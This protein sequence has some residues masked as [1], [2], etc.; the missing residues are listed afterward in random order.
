MILDIGKKK[1]EALNEKLKEAEK[2]DLL[3]F[4]LGAGESLQTFEGID[5]SQAQAQAQSRAEMLGILD[6]GKR[7]RNVVKTY[8]ESIL[9]QQAA[10][11][12]MPKVEKKKKIRL[13]KAY[14]LPRMDEWQMYD[15]ERLNAIQEE[16]EAL[17]KKLLEEE[18]IS[19]GVDGIS[20]D[21]KLL[22][23]EVLEE[24][25]NLLKEG[26]AD[27]S[28]QDFVAFV[29]ASATF[30]REEFDSIA[31]I[32]GKPLKVIEGYASKF[33]GDIGKSRISEKEYE[34]AIIAIERGEKKLN[35]VRSME[36]G[37]SRFVSLF[38]D[39]WSDLEFTPRFIYKDKSFTE[40]E[41]RFLLCWSHKFGHG[42]W[43]AIRFAIRRCRAFRFN[44]H[45][46]SLTE[47][48]IGRRCEQ[49]MRTAVKEID[50]LEQLYREEAGLPPGD[51]EDD[52]NSETETIQLPKYST[53][54]A[55]RKAKEEKET[56]AE[57]SRLEAKVDE[58][59]AE[60]KRIQA[61]LR[62]LERM[63]ENQ[64]KND[65]TSIVGD[66]L[67]EL[68]NL[69]ASSGNKGIN[70]VAKEF[71]LQK[72]FS[73]PQI[74]SKIDE[75]AIKEKRES[76]GD[77]KPMWYIKS[78]FAHLVDLISLRKKRKL[79]S[80]KKAITQKKKKRANENNE[81]FPQYDG[82]EPP[83][84]AKKDF[85]LFCITSRRE[86]KASLKADQRKDKV[87]IYGGNQSLRVSVLIGFF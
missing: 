32:V 28:R 82:I 13:P 45:M 14:R 2:G 36:K 4:K 46:R 62:E 7:E 40:E 21:I 60:M 80:P 8:N 64:S 50:H 86:V 57:K 71:S 26:F 37:T 75:I 63:D 38:Y 56:E 24:K 59:E 6:I 73:L 15:R 77:T 31:N 1:T 52:N 22:S 20:D 17:Y 33:W 44:Y 61:R 35:E 68:V 47:E 65:V 12:A 19:S 10:D 76:E 87:S 42:M 3:D 11:K 78:E 34:R 29:K 79:D 69:V 25:K 83:R 53:M 55:Q 49:L 67:S 72:L 51:D 58:I 16:E 39:P 9:Y 70:V 74:K 54:M 18:K 27:W 48:A 41:D 5:Y 43:R 85:T 23:D 30:G 84:E 81:N 66:N